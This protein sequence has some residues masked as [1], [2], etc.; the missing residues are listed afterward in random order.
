MQIP[1]GYHT[2]TP[3]IVANDA[4]GVVA[5]L[6]RCFDADGS[7]EPGRP[8]EVRIGDSLVLVSEAG[9]REPFPA[10][11]YIYVE[12]VDATFERCLAEG[13]IGVGAPTAVPW[14]DRRGIVSD[15]A[16]N[17]FQI[18]PDRASAVAG[19]RQGPAVLPLNYEMPTLPL[20]ARRVHAHPVV[21]FPEKVPT[22][23][24]DGVQVARAGT[25][26]SEV[27]QFT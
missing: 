19:P 2:A 21:S 12:D 24:K 6:H 17:V 16:G 5:F 15:A 25:T 18:A 26:R 22:G 1:P 7:L 14:G 23:P 9:E 3:R 27:E 13:A 10:M 20:G 8:A 11:L 4:A